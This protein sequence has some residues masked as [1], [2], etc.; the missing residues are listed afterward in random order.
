ML[1]I[2]ILYLISFDENPEQSPKN[3]VIITAL[4]NLKY[5]ELAFTDTHYDRIDREKKYYASITDV[6]PFKENSVQITFDV[7]Y[8]QREESG[9]Y[10]KQ[11]SQHNSQFIAVI[12]EKKSFIVGCDSSHLPFI[13]PAEPILGK[14]LHILQYNGT[15][16]KDGISYYV[17]PHG[18]A[19]VPDYIECKFPEMVQLSLDTDFEINVKTLSNVWDHDLN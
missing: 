19:Y 9:N 6:Q 15:I 3:A 11:K 13:T 18:V 1:V 5:D 17:F 14:A 2:G 7:N 8:F 16:Y 10:V 4:K 12:N